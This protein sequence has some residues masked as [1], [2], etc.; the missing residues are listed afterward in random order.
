MTDT[1]GN[2]PDF[3]ALADLDV[4]TD[5]LFDVLSNPRRRF[6][7]TCLEEFST[8]VPLRD[9][10]HEL[11]TWERDA[12]I[13]EISA[14][15]VT[16]IRVSLYHVHIPKMA[17]VGLVE[18]DEERDAVTLVEDGDNATSLATLPSTR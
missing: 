7:L 8:P 10:A 13:T 4:D 12:E 2:E 1:H 18:Y 17:D 15:D 3:A 11:A 14:D 9:V 6:I 16:S 5:A